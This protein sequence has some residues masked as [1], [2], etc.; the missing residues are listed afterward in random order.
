MAGALA[1][2]FGGIAKKVGGLAYSGNTFAAKVLSF[3]SLLIFP[4]IGAGANRVLMRNPNASIGEMLTDPGSFYSNVLHDPL[5]RYA[6]GPEE[7]VHPE[8]VKT[9]MSGVGE[10]IKGCWTGLKGLWNAGVDG[11]W[12]AGSAASTGPLTPEQL[13]ARDAQ[14]FDRNLRNLEVEAAQQQNTH[15]TSI[16]DYG[17]TVNMAAAP[18]P[19]PLA[20][21]HAAHEAV[22]EEVTTELA[23]AAVEAPVTQVASVA[24]EEAVSSGIINAFFT[25]AAA[26]LDMGGGSGAATTALLAFNK[27]RDL[28]WI[29]GGLSAEGGVDSLD[30]VAV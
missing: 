8:L 20:H 17:G 2:I 5:G 7:L 19:E 10:A 4:A 29:G 6:Y 15:M 27:A 13:M 1:G 25:K 30:L 11:R 14:R 3:G 28:G 21:M 24:A 12:T 16:P 23:S 22:A 26:T 9:G 18:P